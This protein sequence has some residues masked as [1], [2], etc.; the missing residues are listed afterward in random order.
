MDYKVEYSGRK[1]I[2]LTVK[3]N[4]VCV[5]APF[6]T[7]RFII[8]KFVHKHRDW[9]E[10]RLNKAIEYDELNKYLTDDS[11]RKLK[12]AA[13]VYFKAELKKYSSIMNIKYGS[14]K[15]T[16]AEHRFGS[17]SA[18]G[19][20]CFSYRLMLYPVEARE[21]VVVHELAH[22]IEMNHSSRFYAIIQATLPDWKQRRNLLKNI[23][24]ELADKTYL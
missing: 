7:P 11:I 2:S 18:K 19:N 21:Y 9:I 3:D 20:I 23:N 17:C 22:I 16:S 1:S 5:K 4:T 6:F 15:I 24:Y 12:V 14:M 13:K 8:D 10:I